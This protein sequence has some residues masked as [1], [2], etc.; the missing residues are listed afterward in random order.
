VTLPGPWHDGSE[1]AQFGRSEL[2]HE[3]KFP[4]DKR[5]SALAFKSRHLSFYEYTP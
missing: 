2:G 3:A 1:C 5:V 4:S